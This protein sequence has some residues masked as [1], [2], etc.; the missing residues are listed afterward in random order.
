MFVR[1]SV[2]AACFG[3]TLRTIAL[4]LLFMPCALSDL[5][6][7]DDTIN[8]VRGSSATAR[9]HAILGDIHKYLYSYN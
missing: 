5:M 2:S 4:V 3:T 8:G 6:A 9:A 1:V 7:H